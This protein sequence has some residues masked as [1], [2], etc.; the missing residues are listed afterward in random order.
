MRLSHRSPTHTQRPKPQ[1]HPAV[2]NNPSLRPCH[3]PESLTAARPPRT[4]WSPA[5]PPARRRQAPRA[6]P[7]LGDWWALYD[8]GP[9]VVAAWPHDYCHPYPEEEA[10]RRAQVGSSWQHPRADYSDYRHMAHWMEGAIGL[11]LGHAV[12]LPLPP[13]PTQPPPGHRPR[14]PSRF[15]ASD[16]V[17]IGLVSTT[18]LRTC[19]WF[20]PDRRRSGALRSWSGGSCERRTWPRWPQVGEGAGEGG[21]AQG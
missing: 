15:C 1:T 6:H 4:P 7:D 21:R 14:S 20:V 9:E 10:R 3:I 12:P 18:P 16:S 17:S 5:R 13:P 2:P 11:Q 19:L 8:Y